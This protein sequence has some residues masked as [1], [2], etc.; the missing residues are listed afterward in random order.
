M[1]KQDDA[2][3]FKPELTPQANTE[4]FIAHMERTDKQFAGL[5]RDNLSEL[6]A[7]TERERPEARKRFNQSVIEA[8]EAPVD[9]EEGTPA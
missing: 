6:L 7:A 1:P 3:A 5:L 4:A 8:L 9:E 2:F